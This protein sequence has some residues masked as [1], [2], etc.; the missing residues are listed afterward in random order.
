MV[1]RDL[2]GMGGGTVI[3]SSFLHLVED[4]R[5]F[6]GSL[7][8]RR[9]TTSARVTPGP[10]RGRADE[11]SYNLHIIIRSE[12]EQ[13]MLSGDLPV[14]D[15]PGAWNEAYRT[16]LGVTPRNDAEGCL[17]DGHWSEGMIGYFPTYPLGAF[18]EATSDVCW[19]GPATGSTAMAA[20]T[21]PR[22]WWSGRRGSIDL[23]SD[24]LRP[25]PRHPPSKFAELLGALDDRHDVI[26][27]QRSEF[28]CESGDSVGEEDFGFADGFGVQ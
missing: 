22:N 18:A 7:P 13:A 27:R 10:N 3:T 24:R 5:R 28:A 9:M 25:P 17:Q 12:P 23:E 1:F 16:Y 15:L 21:R 6:K 20:G 11:V 8:A 4:L 26:A 2:L 14:A 19:D